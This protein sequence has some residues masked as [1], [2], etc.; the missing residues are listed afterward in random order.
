MLFRS[1]GDINGDGIDDIII[2]ARSAGDNSQGQSYV[3]FGVAANAAPTITSSATAS[4]AENQTS[5]IDVDATDDNDSEGSGLTY[6]LSGGDDSALFSIDTNTGIVTFNSAPDFETPGDANTDNDYEFQVTVTDST[7]LTDVRDITVTVTDID[8]SNNGGTIDG[9]GNNDT[10]N[11][12]SG[13]DT[14]RGFGGSDEIFGNAGND[15]LIGNGGEDT[16]NGDAGNDT[17]SGGGGNDTLNGNA[18]DDRLVGQ[19]GNDVL[20][21]GEGSDTLVGNDG[22]DTLNGDAGNDRL[23]G[24]SGNDVLVGGEG[25]DTLIGSGDND[26]L[27]G[28]LG[29]DRLTGGNGADTFV[30]EASTTD[31]DRA[32]ITDY[33]DGTDKIGLPSGLSFGSNIVARNNGAGTATLIRDTD[34]NTNLAILRGVDAANID[35]S[36]FV[37]V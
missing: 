2:G 31:E 1:A 32:I 9:T 8:E 16:L 10:L 24:R 21:G 22:D 27:S 18:G 11:G 15:S 26:T 35:S 25:S 36:D 28:G 13:D 37:S 17:L 7:G 30:L 4:V 34:A 6:S 23:I 3:V 33:A 5:A 12:S 29:F 14:I 20:F 19:N